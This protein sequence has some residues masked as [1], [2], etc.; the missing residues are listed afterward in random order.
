MSAPDS[1]NGFSPVASPSPE[2]VAAFT[3]PDN[4][5]D[6]AAV[7]SVVNAALAALELD[8]AFI[9]PGDRV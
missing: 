2:R 9:R 1:A 7:Q 5:A 8:P 6:P 4:Y 3:G